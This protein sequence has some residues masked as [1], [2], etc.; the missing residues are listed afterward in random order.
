MKQLRSV[1]FIICLFCS[2]IYSFAQEVGNATYYS[3]KLH[4][5]LTASG[6]RYDKDSLTC[7]HRTLPFGTRIKVTNTRNMKDVIVTVTDRG[8]HN[9]RFLIDLSYAAAKELD[10]IKM[11]VCPVELVIINPES[12]KTE[13]ESN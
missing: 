10:I 5:R 2:V 4:G 6:M 3:N 11:G 1:I 9:K 13:S 8:P 7:A 12:P